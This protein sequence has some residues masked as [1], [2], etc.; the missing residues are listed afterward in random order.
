MIHQLRLAKMADIPHAIFEQNTYI[1]SR[2][3]PGKSIDCHANMVGLCSV[4]LFIPLARCISV[5]TL[6]LWKDISCS[7]GHAHNQCAI[8][9]Y[10]ST[11]LTFC[12]RSVCGPGC[13]CSSSRFCY[14]HKLHKYATKCNQ[15]I[16]VK[17][18]VLYIAADTNTHRGSFSCYGER[19]SP[20]GQF[21]C[22]VNIF[23]GSCFVFQWLTA[24]FC[25]AVNFFQFHPL[26]PF[27]GVGVFHFINICHFVCFSAFFWVDRGVCCKNKHL[28]NICQGPQFS[29]ISLSN[30]LCISHNWTWGGVMKF[31]YYV[32]FPLFMYFNFLFI[33]VFWK[34]RY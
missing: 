14:L 33:F 34:C 20:C 29:I 15:C 26:D 23:A 11:R 31:V 9:T 28:V 18:V 22:P 16:I 2:H 17:R 4:S 3:P 6:S 1:I 12:G 7:P 24:P 27:S 5:I 13:V 8:T 10:C 19:G 32:K 30:W 25:A 21:I